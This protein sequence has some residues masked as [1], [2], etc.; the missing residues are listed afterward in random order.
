MCCRHSH[1]PWLLQSVSQRLAITTSVNSC[2]V[3]KVSTHVQAGTLDP[4]THSTCLHTHRAFMVTKDGHSSMT[5]AL[6]KLATALPQCI[7][8]QL[9]CCAH[10]YQAARPAEYEIK[11]SV[12]HT[13]MH[14][15]VYTCRSRQ[16]LTA[17]SSC[18]SSTFLPPYNSAGQGT[19][20]QEFLQ[21]ERRLHS[22]HTI[23]VHLLTAA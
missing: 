7:R 8:L 13:C 6:I 11:P 21:V 10:R 4:A 3:S 22:S 15:G 17:A 2:H 19:A 14:T 18:T 16:R 5:C 23:A 20:L 12:L 9:T 1:T